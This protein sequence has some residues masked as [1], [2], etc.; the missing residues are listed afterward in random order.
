MNA[1]DAVSRSGP[2]SLRALLR[3]E[4]AVPHAALDAMFAGMEE[5]D[6]FDLYRRFVRMN[7]ACHHALEPWLARSP[8]VDLLPGWPGWSRLAAL[9]EDMACMNL[10]PLASP[11][12][13]TGTPPLP[14]AVGSAYVLEGSRL[15]AA[16]IRRRFTERGVERLWPGLSLH[17]LDRS[18]AGDGIKVF[19]AELAAIEWSEAER[20]RCV[21]AARA[22][23]DGFRQ[24]ATRA[25]E[26][27]AR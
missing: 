25:G 11:V 23:F 14:E 12:I 1:H 4:T 26:R 20:A 18:A 7:H 16:V 19:M 21:A 3:R 6:D 10:S 22:T 15:G 24:T 2:L 17:Y 8:L 9:D 27:V 5:A 13:L